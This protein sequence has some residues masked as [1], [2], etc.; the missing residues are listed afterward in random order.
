MPLRADASR[1]LSRRRRRPWD[2]AGRGPRGQFDGAGRFRFTV[3]RRESPRTAMDQRAREPEFRRTDFGVGRRIHVG[4]EQ[5]MHQLTP[6]SNDP[7]ADPSG[8]SFWLQDVK[9]RETWN[10]A[11]D[12]AAAT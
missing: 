11:A 2:A 8:E 10:I 1:M 4:R 7:V 9:T 12:R 6:W 5:S 3:E